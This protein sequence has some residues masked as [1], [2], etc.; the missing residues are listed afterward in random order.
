MHAITQRRFEDPGRNSAD[1][2]RTISAIYDLPEV[3]DSDEVIVLTRR[4]SPC[5]HVRLDTMH[6]RTG[7]GQ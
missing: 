6:A 4:G 3:L 2:L 1:R 5:L 7:A